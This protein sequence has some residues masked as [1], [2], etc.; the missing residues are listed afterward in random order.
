M[1]SDNTKNFD[2]NENIIYERNGIME[3]SKLTVTV[4]EMAKMIGVNRQTAYALAKMDNFP[5]IRI[6]E[7]RIIIPIDALN[8][9][10]NESAFKRG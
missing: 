6:S 1:K 8:K 2:V 7:R 3:N 9:W 5:A 4:D 10:L